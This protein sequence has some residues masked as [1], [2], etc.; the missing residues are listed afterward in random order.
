[1]YGW[2]TVTRSLFYL[3]LTLSGPLFTRGQEKVLFNDNWLFV[4][5]P[6]S[7]LYAGIIAGNAGTISWEHVSL[8]HTANIEPVVKTQQEWQGVCFYKKQLWVPVADKG[9]HIALQFEA[10]MNDASIYLNGAFVFR[11]TGGYLPFY[12]DISDKIRYGATNSIIIRLDN[13]DNSEI[14]PGKKLN[15]L[16]FNYYSGLYR[17]AWLVKKSSLHISDAIAAQTKAGGGILLHYDS[18]SA[19]AAVLN[20]QTAIKN[21]GGNA[22][23]YR[24]RAT[25]FDRKGEKVAQ[26]ISAPVTISG[27]NQAR[28]AQQLSIRE[29]DL[30][31]PESPV[32]YRLSIEIV[33]DK[34]VAD[35]E[36]LLT[37]IRSIQI[38]NKQLYLNGSKIVLRGTNRHQEYPYIGYALSDNAQYRDA[39]KIKNAGFNFVRTSHYPHSPAFIEACDELGLLVMDAIPGWQYFGNETFIRNS[40]RDTRDM[41][42]RDRNHPSVILW[43]AS[44]NE[45]GMS[46]E[47]MQMA[48]QAV[49]EELPFN[50]TYT[51]G[52]KDD[53]YDIF[54]PARQ[55][56]KAPDYWKKYNKDKPLLISEYGDWEYYAHNAGFNQKAF[57]DLQPEE[58]TSRQ[59]RQYGQK[60]LLQQALNYQEAH[61][62][63]LN[64][65]FLG[66]ANWLM[67][68]YK[69]GYV[70]DIESSGIMDIMRLPKFSYYFYQ[71]QR[72]ATGSSSFAKPV[73]FI[74]NYWERQ[75]DTIVKVYS[76][77][78][79]VALFLDGKLV[80]RQR[81]D[82]AD[83]CRN[84]AHPPFTFRLPVFVPGKLS[85]VGYIQ[86]RK[87][88]ETAVET[89][90]NAQAVRLEVDE[91]GKKLQAGKNDIVF[92]Y[93]CI[94]D[95]K[96]N[97]LP[98]ADD[99]ITL[100]INKGDA[101]IIGPETV[102]S[103]AGIAAFLLRAGKTPG[104]IV[105]TATAGNLDQHSLQLRSTGPVPGVVVAHQPAAS[106][107]YI[108]SPSICILPDG[109][110]LAAHDFFGKGNPENESVIYRSDNKG[111]SW[112][113]IA[114]LR[115]FWSVLFVHKGDVY[116]M[117]PAKANG[118]IVIRRSADGGFTWSEPEDERSGIIL[119][120][121]FHCAPT[122]V[123]EQKGR[124]WRTFEDA[125][126]G[127]EWPKRYGAFMLSAAID[128][129]LLQAAS[130]RKTNAV[131]FDSTYLNNTFKGWLEGNAVAGPKGHILDV[132]RVHT[133]SKEQEYI[134][135]ID[136]DK[137][138][139]IASFNPAAGFVALS[140]GSKKF[141][142]HYDKTTKRYWTIVNYVLP[143]YKGIVQLDRVRN[144]QVLCSSKDLQQWQYHQI[145]LNHADYTVHGF[146]YV[147]WTFDGKDI[148]L[149]SRTAYDDA[150]GGA[151]N[152][153]NTN[154]MTFHRIEDFRRLKKER[155]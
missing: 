109:A 27:N 134:A 6:D 1:M 3:L 15:A 19:A 86:N 12:V 155:L 130:W 46:K 90:G 131:G 121:Q 122:P 13:R 57:N 94:K 54:I 140:G 63:N 147:D 33:Q 41:V 21:D 120:G 20:I 105:I 80:S 119:R 34:G 99:S 112:E 151:Q 39:W 141:T 144:T 53:V 84:L 101:Q 79:E 10:A 26:N 74:A 150:D 89:P 100:K 77:C 132:I 58:R 40:I 103:E 115:Q 61:N 93:A 29:P 85:A 154:Y 146:Q 78:E 82:T 108:G 67:F 135:L 16:D 102:R 128:A 110:Y 22:Q 45:S 4:K 95:A 42:R 32:L 87:I 73:L 118:D 138:G 17:N 91:S 83:N 123:I 70:A 125:S 18:V 11:H 149:L 52:W 106:G 71:S 56:A 96:G 2:Q 139:N 28:T 98:G 148:I 36:T 97:T 111:K 30:W 37:G 107:K 136:I 49:K 152:Y 113:K 9:K 25:L 23:Q 48:N 143:A 88:A 127:T 5:D 81:P 62:D 35:S 38:K 117:G 69:R 59:F 8:P 76:N 145:I 153:H 50:D 137:N 66:D 75:T 142:I 31:S 60:R 64:G 92:V 104:E 55:H 124:L 72:S 14:P 116:F 129:D 68:D 126:G 47:Y 114:Q 65:N 133:L 44:L 7:L 43:E 24:I 51:A